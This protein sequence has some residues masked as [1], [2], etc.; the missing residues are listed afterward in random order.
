MLAEAIEVSVSTMGRIELGQQV[1]STDILQRIAVALDT[2][3]AS[4]VRNSRPEAAS[5]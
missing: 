1:I 4:L 3:S 5:A 2:T